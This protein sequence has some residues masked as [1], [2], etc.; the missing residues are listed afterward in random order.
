MENSTSGSEAE[1]RLSGPSVFEG[2]AGAI[3]AADARAEGLEHRSFPTCGRR[4]FAPSSASILQLYGVPGDWNV[5][6]NPALMGQ[7]YLVNRQAGFKLRLLRNGGRPTPAA[8]A[9]RPE[10]AAPRQPGGPAVAAG[11]TGSS[12]RP[13]ERTTAALDYAAAYVSEEG[14]TLRVVHPVEAGK[15]GQMV[16]FDVDFAVLPGGSVFEQLEFRGDEERQD[17]FRTEIDEADGDAD[18]Q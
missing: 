18:E 8:S 14:F 2:I 17:F 3:A 9:R 4:S 1:T 11:P 5:D 13:A 16:R 12:R 10:P 15:Y 7:L 6:G